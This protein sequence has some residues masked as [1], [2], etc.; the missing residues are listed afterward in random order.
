MVIKNIEKM[1]NNL[2]SLPEEWCIQLNDYKDWRNVF[3]KYLRFKS[4]YKGNSLGSYYSDNECS[5]DLLEKGY[6][7][8]TIKQFKQWVLKEVP[9]YE[10]YEIY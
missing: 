5:S 10:N 9:D 7:E 2:T 6:T 1:E 4:K 3:S 8:I